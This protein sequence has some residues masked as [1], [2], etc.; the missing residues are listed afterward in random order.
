MTFVS[1]PAFSQQWSVV[2]SPNPSGLRNIIR[3]IGAIS[4]N[5]VWAVG[6]YDEQPSFSLI[7]HWNGTSWTTVTSPNPGSNYNSLYDVEGLTSNNVYAVGNFTV[8][9]GNT[10]M[11]ILHWNGTVWDQ[12]STPSVAGGSGLESVLMFGPN[13]VYSAGY[14][15]IGAPGPLAGTLVTHW[16]GSSWNIETTPN[17]SNNRSNFLSD[18]K[19]L[20]SDDVWAVGYSRNLGENYQGLVMHKTGTT[21]SL[22]SVPQ[23][24]AENFLYDV[25]VI[26]SDNIWASG[27]YNNGGNYTPYY[28][29]Y[30][31]T[32]WSFVASP[33]GG[34]GIVHSSP[35]DIWSTGS[36]FV[37]YDGN[38]WN[39]MPAVIPAEGNMGSISGISTTDIWAAGNYTDGTATKTLIMHYGTTV[40]IDPVTSIPEKFS[41]SQNYPNPFNPSTIINYNIP[42]SGNVKLSIYDGFGR[43]VTTL[44]NETQSA[45]TYNITWNASTFSSGVYYY[46]LEAGSLFEIKK[47][48]LV[49]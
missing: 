33:G 29:H 26:A 10:Q 4:S 9:P 7:Q 34:A 22:V 35:N 28:L 17:Q 31:G 30:N 32:S 36:E 38:S 37:H 45:G 14:K 8:P 20:S 49:K 47:M 16:N 43:L 46:K 21:W 3:G 23:P 48:L 2:P 41:L 1:I 12:E 13:D 27:A 24:G 15:T 39:I 25:D 5:D 19:G 42:Q 11:L 40:G 18:I 44:V 6:E